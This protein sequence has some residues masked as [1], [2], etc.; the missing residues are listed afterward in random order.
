MFMLIKLFMVWNIL[1]DVTVGKFGE[2]L[3]MQALPVKWSYKPHAFLSSV[4]RK[5]YS[6]ERL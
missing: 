6:L 4:V 2:F 3:L 5:L 1:D